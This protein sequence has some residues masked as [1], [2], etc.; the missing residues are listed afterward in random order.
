M[1]RLY[2]EFCLNCNTVTRWVHPDLEPGLPD[3]CTKCGMH[4]WEQSET[5]NKRS[6]KPAASPPAPPTKERK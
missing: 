1:A 3:R 6:C 5:A 4:I 2:D